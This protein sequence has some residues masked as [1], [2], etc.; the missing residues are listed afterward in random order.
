MYGLGIGGTGTIWDIGGGKDRYGVFSLLKKKGFKVL[1]KGSEEEIRFNK[2]G[3]MNRIGF[4]ENFSLL[5]PNVFK[6][7]TRFN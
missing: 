6:H 7:F 4:N 1:E 2:K 3:Y 5:D